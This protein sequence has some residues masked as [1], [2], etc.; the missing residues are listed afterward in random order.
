MP[1]KIILTLTT[2]LA[3]VALC[4][5]VESSE[6]QEALALPVAAGD[7][8]GVDDD[9][10]DDKNDRSYRR[11]PGRSGSVVNTDS[12]LLANGV[13]RLSLA[14]TSV[15]EATEA[16]STVVAQTPTPSPAID[17]NGNVLADTMLGASEAVNYSAVVVT[18]SNIA[19]SQSPDWVPESI[20]TR[21]AI[22]INGSRSLGDLMK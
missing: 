12:A 4:G 13:E 9:H 6:S 14:Q 1:S 3:G 17:A 10:A 19:G 16:E 18:G 20:Y 21:E 2:A 8:D 15:A 11:R 7:N 5:L 22:E